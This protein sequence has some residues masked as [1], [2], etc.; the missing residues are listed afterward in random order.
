MSVIKDEEELYQEL[1]KSLNN[2]FM[3][4][5][6]ICH[7]V[8]NIKLNLYHFNEKTYCYTNTSLFGIT[9]I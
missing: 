3:H 7:Q 6:I 2:I 4:R 1:E 8:Q 9:K 5:H